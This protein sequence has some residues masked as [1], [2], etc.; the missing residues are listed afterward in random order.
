MRVQSIQQ[1][2]KKK[3]KQPTIAGWHSIWYQDEETQI[4]TEA[5]RSFISSFMAAARWS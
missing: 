4:Y 5:L 3:K 1:K 2:E